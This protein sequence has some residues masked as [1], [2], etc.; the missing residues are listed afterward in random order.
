MQMPCPAT[1]DRSYIVIKVPNVSTF[2]NQDSRELLCD[3]LDHEQ[4]ADTHH[5]VVARERILDGAVDLAELGHVGH[6]HSVFQSI[7][8]LAWPDDNHGE[9]AGWRFLRRD[10]DRTLP[11]ACAHREHHAV[12]RARAWHA[13]AA[14]IDH[15]QLAR[16]RV[17]T[18]HR[19]LANADADWDEG[20]EAAMHT[21]AELDP[22]LWRLR[23][24]SGDASSSRYVPGMQHPD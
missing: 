6:R 14:V 20:A 13:F 7:A 8:A 23:A 11:G 15:R 12:N 1:M 5:R 19:V 21:R 3:R 22:L 4:V 24:R 16:L 2:P 18:L 10:L 9:G 17:E